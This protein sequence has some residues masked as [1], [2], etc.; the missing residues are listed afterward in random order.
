[1]F[2]KHNKF[3]INLNKL[4]NKNFKISYKDFNKIFNNYLAKFI[5]IIALLNFS[6]NT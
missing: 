6:Y 2:D 5:I 1:M 3:I 4:V